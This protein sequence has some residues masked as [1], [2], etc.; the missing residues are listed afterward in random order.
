MIRHGEK[1]PKLPNGEDAEGLSARGVDRAKALPNVFGADSQ[2]NIGYILAEKPKKRTFNTHH[3]LQPSLTVRGRTADEKHARPYETVLPLSHALHLTIDATIERD[4]VKAAADAAKA[5][6][7]SG[8]VLVCWEHH[9]LGKI[10]EAIGVKGEVVYPDDRFDII[11]T[12]PAPYDRITAVGS[13]SVPGLDD[14]VGG[15][16]GPVVGGS[17]E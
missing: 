15:E 16:V 10:A 2:Y 9:E 5:Y 1:P 13:E 6:S 3:F 17:E 12:V 8:N 14:G 4:D 7:G 11:W